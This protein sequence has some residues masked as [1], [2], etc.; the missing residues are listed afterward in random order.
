MINYCEFYRLVMGVN[1]GNMDRKWLKETHVHGLIIDAPWLLL[2]QFANKYV[3]CI[4]VL[5]HLGF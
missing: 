2:A 5:I 3:P 4:I 1:G